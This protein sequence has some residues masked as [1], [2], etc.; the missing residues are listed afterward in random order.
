MG[1]HSKLAKIAGELENIQKT[2]QM[3]KGAGGY[4]FVQASEIARILRPIFARESLTFVPTSA[5]V[6]D[7]HDEERDGRSPIHY[8]T[9]RYDWLVTDGETGE[10]L[11]V[12]SIGS[13]FDTGDKAA[14]KAA[15]GAQKYA[16]LTALMLG[17]TDDAEAVQD[18]DEERTT[19]A[20]PVGG[21]P[22]EPKNAPAAKAPPT[23]ARST[24]I[25]DSMRK[26]LFAKS[27]DK[28]LTEDQLRYVVGMIAQ[29]HSTKDLT[30][31]EFDKVIHALD[32]ESMIAQAKDV[33]GV[34]S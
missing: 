30:V 29:K 15:T 31:A 27:H 11:E 1:V 33:K 13:G 24:G 3:E 2:G 16:Y 19:K 20:E 21:A 23:V 26:K 14:Y 12:V 9:V 32:E 7:L 34:A 5:V 22:R 10:S 17:S 8:I 28:G 4:K 25:S 18:T 6:L